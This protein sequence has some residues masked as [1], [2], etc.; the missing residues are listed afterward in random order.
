MLNDVE[1]SPYI[2]AISGKIGSGKNY[3]A[4]KLAQVYASEGKTTA[5]ISYAIALK[6]EA[7]AIIEDF[8]TYPVD[9]DALSEKY[10]IGITDLEQ[11]Y[12]FVINDL[13][14]K[15]LLTGW[16][17]SE[18]IRRFLQYLGTDIRRK[19]NPNYWV[20]KIVN[21]IPKNVDY[22][23]ITDVRFPNEAEKAL[24]LGGFLFRL[25]VP[26]EVILSRTSTRDGMKYSAEALN[27][28]SEKALDDYKKFDAY[29]G[30]DFDPNSLIKN[31]VSVREQEWRNKLV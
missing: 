7:S 29:V 4:E 21:Y 18:G 10:D 16:D 13:K 26:E 23:F 8:R 24:D 19:Q 1:V 15:P 27:H 31:F 6:D 2:I 12:V 5:E 14:R 11:L 28:K 9:F 30:V 22:V 25:D 20:D 17:R 3:L